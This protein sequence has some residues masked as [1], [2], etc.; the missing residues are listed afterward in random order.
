MSTERVH[1]LIRAAARADAEV[2]GSS[3]GYAPL[4]KLICS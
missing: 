1:A 4:E 3:K 2:K